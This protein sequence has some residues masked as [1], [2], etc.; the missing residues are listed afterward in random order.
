[1]P[2]KTITNQHKD[3]MTFFSCARV[4]IPR[5][6]CV[7]SLT[8]VWPLSTHFNVLLS[9]QEMFLLVSTVSGNW[10]PSYLQRHIWFIS[11][12]NVSLSSGFSLSESIGRLKL[13]KMSFLTSHHY[14]FRI[15]MFLHQTSVSQ[16]RRLG[17]SSHQVD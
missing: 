7:T 12:D 11:D 9:T 15:R 2:V 16:L 4:C 8:E 3:V 14:T 17:L 13:N 1:M 5:K 10:D 6:G